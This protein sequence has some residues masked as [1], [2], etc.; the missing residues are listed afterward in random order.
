MAPGTVLDAKGPAVHQSC[1]LWSLDSVRGGGQCTSQ[2]CEGMTLGHGVMGPVPLHCPPAHTQLE[3]AS[4]WSFSKLQWDSCLRLAP[5]GYCS[6]GQEGP[7]G[8]GD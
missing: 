8:T 6:F 3:R 2:D 1:D 5:R 4:C 7:L